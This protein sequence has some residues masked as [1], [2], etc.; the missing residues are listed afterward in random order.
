MAQHTPPSHRT[1]GFT[2]IELLVAV[3]ILAVV[4]VMAWRGL[5]GMA[6]GNTLAREHTDAVL[7]LESGLAQWGADLDAMQSLPST[8][9]LLWDGGVLR[10]TRRHSADP[11]QGVVVV[12]WSRGLRTPGQQWLR[13]QSE[14]VQTVAQWQ[15]AW[16]A[17][18]LWAQNPSDA[19]RQREVAL[20]P[21]EDWQVYYFRGSNQPTSAVSEGPN[22]PADTT[23]PD[24][25]RLVL[26]IAPTHPLGGELVRDWV[27]PSLGGNSQ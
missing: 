26:T 2:L 13:W 19:A 9:A 15:T 5:D 3:A 14:P 12:A 16:Q 4:G 18:L 20:A 6:R 22:T 17:A 10:I 25:V 8:T 7:A 27:R 1:Q 23:A 11:A 21:L 24:G